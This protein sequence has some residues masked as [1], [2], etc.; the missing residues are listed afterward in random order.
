MVGDEEVCDVPRIRWM[1]EYAEKHLIK[2][3]P[4]AIVNVEVDWVDYLSFHGNQWAIA[5][6]V[7]YPDMEESEEIDDAI[8]QI[9]EDAER[10]AERA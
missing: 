9:I 6:G 8:R 1:A 4:N 10:F 3:F 7:P 5:S 2:T